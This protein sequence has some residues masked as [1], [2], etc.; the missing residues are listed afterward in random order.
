VDA[1]ACPRRG[2]ALCVS[3]GNSRR[4]FWRGGASSYNSTTTTTSSQVKI[5]LSLIEVN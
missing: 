1:V 3:K 2:Y 5:N 4:A